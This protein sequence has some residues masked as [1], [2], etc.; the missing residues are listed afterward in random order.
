MLVLAIELIGVALVV[1]GLAMFSIPAAL[2]V[3][4]IGVLA[5]GVALERG[6]VTF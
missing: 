3:L 1:G 4:G 6:G 5:F 2:V